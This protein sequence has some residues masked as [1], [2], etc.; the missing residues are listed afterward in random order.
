MTNNNLYKNQCIIF[1]SMFEKNNIEDIV[2]IAESILKNPITILDTSYQ[3]ITKSNLSKKNNSSIETNSGNCYLRDSFIKLMKKN[4]CI[5]SIYSTNKSFF[6]YDKENNQELLFCP[7]IINNLTA[8]YIGIIKEETDFTDEHLELTNTLAKVLAVQIE[9]DNIFITNS[10]SDYEYYLTDLL[11]NKIDNIDYLKSRLTNINFKLGKF[12]T[13]LAIP[14][15]QVTNNYKHNFALKELFKNIKNIFIN[16]IFTYYKENI[17]FLI[18]S[19]TNTIITENEFNRLD[20]FLKLNNLKCGVSITFD[21]ILKT[22]NYFLQSIFASSLKDKNNIIFFSNHIHNYLFNYYDSKFENNKIDLYSLIHP[23]IKTLQSYDLKHNTELL[24]TLEIY[25]GHNRN[26][27]LTIQALNIH[28]STFF[29]RFHRIEEIINSSLNL[30][31]MLFKLELS[32]KILK[33]KKDKDIKL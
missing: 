8:F 33:Y 25:L 6:F 10:G 4:K 3:I 28:K 16:S 31:N 23:S 18:T 20:K 32:I 19:N 9:K 21:N 11:L 12:F 27:N 22:S 14:F 2:N 15:E 29:Y 13:I 7:I 30:N 17:V 24:K 1:N 5:D 26:V